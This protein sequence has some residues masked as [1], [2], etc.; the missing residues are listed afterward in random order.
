MS[1]GR[2]SRSRGGESAWKFL[3]DKY[4]TNKDGRI[5]TD[6]YQRDQ[7]TFLR[8]DRNKDGALS[9]LEVHKGLTALGVTKTP[10]EVV[11]VF[12]N[13]DTDKTKRWQQC[14]GITRSRQYPINHGKCLQ[15]SLVWSGCP[16]R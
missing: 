16:Y 7:D 11:T 1:R 10:E 9:V 13:F 3:A 6:E 5:T 15:M 2:G 12:S 8:L 4:D 14:G